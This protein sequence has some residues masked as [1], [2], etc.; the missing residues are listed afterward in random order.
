[1][2]VA[3]SVIAITTIQTL[4]AQT[5]AQRVARAP[6]GVIHLQFASR[7]GTCGD[8]RDMVGYRKALFANSFQSMGSWHSTD[9][10]P[11][12]VRVTLSIAGG[13]VVRARTSVGGVWPRTDDRVTDLG[14]LSAPEAAG[15]FFS[16]VPALEK[17]SDKSRILLPAVLADA[18]D[19][20]PQLT[21]LARDG[22]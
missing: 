13:K 16:L 21:A 8:G 2:I 3:V 14:V 7:S 12:A 5:L 11:G 18:G 22:G 15:Y 19:V 6:D 17:A 9:C 4:P 1:M 20:T 10:V